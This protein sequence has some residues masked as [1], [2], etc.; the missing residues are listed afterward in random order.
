MRYVHEPAVYAQVYSS[1][2]SAVRVGVE[3]RLSR[4]GHGHVSLLPSWRTAAPST[5]GAASAR[6]AG[7]AKKRIVGG[8]ERAVRRKGGAV[9]GRTGGAAEEGRRTRARFYAGVPSRGP[10]SG[11]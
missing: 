2:L 4:A 9:V 11:P 5:A 3:P 6:R 1:P 7:M 10:V 8:E